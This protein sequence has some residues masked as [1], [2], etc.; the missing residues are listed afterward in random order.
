MNSQQRIRGPRIK[1][2][3]KQFIVGE[4]IKYSNKPRLAL[5]AEIRDK[6]EHLGEI[7]PSEETLIKMISD[8]RSNKTG[9]IDS[10]WTIGCCIKYDIPT[11]FIP[12]LLDEQKRILA[13]RNDVI[14]PEDKESLRNEIMGGL[15]LTIR[16]ARWFVK[17][18]PVVY[19]L[20]KKQHPDNPRLQ[21]GAVTVFAKQYAHRERVAEILGK[22]NPDTSDIDNVLMQEDVSEEQLADSIW[23]YTFSDDTKKSNSEAAENFQGYN[24][25]DYET[26]LGP[27][28]D[29]QIELLNEWGRAIIKGAVI[30]REW[31]KEHPEI[32][33]LVTSKGGDFSSL[34]SI[35]QINQVRR[36]EN[37]K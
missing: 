35:L 36:R 27:L 25:E 19:E 18:Y 26:L 14:L 22:D 2:S 16:Q 32:P 33:E 15:V 3:I 29:I 7:S 28:T 21:Q 11:E 17:L 8:A 5:A 24:R 20:A 4:A 31:E 13:S 6:I 23:D 37:E 1:P 30:R 10:P 34:V 12:I 9:P